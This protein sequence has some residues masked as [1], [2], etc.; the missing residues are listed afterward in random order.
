MET[1]IFVGDFNAGTTMSTTFDQFNFDYF[2][3]SFVHVSFY[4]HKY[5]LSA[6]LSK[7]IINYRTEVAHILKVS[8]VHS[9]S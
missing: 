3:L 5:I 6:F 9:V 4:V 7:L 2:F 1:Y 8:Q